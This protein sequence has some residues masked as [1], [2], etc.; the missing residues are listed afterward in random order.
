MLASVL[1]PPAPCCARLS[2][3]S[4]RFHWKRPSWNSTCAERAHFQL[5]LVCCWHLIC[6]TTML[7]LR[8]AQQVLQALPLG[9]AVLE[10]HLRRTSAL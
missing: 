4:R 9:A 1:P 8:Q 5:K 2:R 10:Q 7:W 6:A 3:F